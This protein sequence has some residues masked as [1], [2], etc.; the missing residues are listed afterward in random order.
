MKT[1]A[2]LLSTA[3]MSLS[4]P[5]MAEMLTVSGIGKSLISADAAL[6][7]SDS[8]QSAKKDAIVQLVN[9]INGPRA[10]DDPA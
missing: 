6:T 7:R 10:A 8:L 1:S 3:I 2:L 4:L 9:K 5:A